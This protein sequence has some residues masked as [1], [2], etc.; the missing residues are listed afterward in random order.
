MNMKYLKKQKFIKPL[1]LDNYE[2]NMDEYEELFKKLEI[3]RNLITDVHF[4]FNTNILNNID[5]NLKLNE[6]QK[7]P[8]IDLDSLYSNHTVTNNEILE[9]KKNLLASNKNKIAY[10]EL[11]EDNFYQIYLDKEIYIDENNNKTYLKK[12]RKI[13]F[14]NNNKTIKKLEIILLKYKKLK[15]EYKE[16]LIDIL[17]K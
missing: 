12:K 13:P 5:P 17:N 15:R 8:E 6:P 3:N 14:E 10:R 2:F 9:L 16:K 7:E 11:T 1:K 4:N